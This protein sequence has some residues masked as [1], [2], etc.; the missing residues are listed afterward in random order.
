MNIADH[1]D[2]SQ[3]PLENVV[4]EAGVCEFGIGVHPGNHKDCIAL[5]YQPAHHRFLLFQIENIKLVD[6]RWNHKQRIGIDLWR[7]RL[8]LNQLHQ[9]IL[10][11]DLAR[12]CR[13]IHA[14]LEGIRVTLTDP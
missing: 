1:I 13:E 6:E 2:G 3:H 10:E 5:F 9:I 7:T 12:C 4:F 8:V 11:D 14:K